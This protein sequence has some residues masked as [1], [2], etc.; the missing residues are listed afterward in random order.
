MRAY[1]IHWGSV[2]EGHNASYP[3]GKCMFFLHLVHLVRQGG[4]WVDVCWGQLP[5]Q[6][7]E[8]GCLVGLLMFIKD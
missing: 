1:Y 4:G 7:C 6:R 8:G 5:S 2:S 3:E